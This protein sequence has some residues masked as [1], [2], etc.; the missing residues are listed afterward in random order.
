[1]LSIK[2]SLAPRL[3]ALA[4]LLLEFLPRISMFSTGSPIRAASIHWFTKSALRF[5]R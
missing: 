2:P 3:I 4:F 1:V 5:F